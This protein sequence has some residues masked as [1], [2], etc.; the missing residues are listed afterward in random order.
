MTRYHCEAS[1]KGTKKIDSQLINNKDNQI[2]AAIASWIAPETFYG[3]NNVSN[4]DDNR[5][6]T[7]ANM[8]NAKTL[9]FGCGYQ[10]NCGQDVHISC[11]YNLMQ[12]YDCD[13]ET[14]AM[15]YAR[16]C[17]LK[18]SEQSEREG[19]GENVYIYNAPNAVPADA[20]E[21]AAEHWWGQ[22]FLDGIN[23]KV[24]FKQS[25]KDKSIDQKSF[26]QMAWAKSTKLGCG[27]Q[28]CGMKSFVVCRYSPA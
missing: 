5:L 11:I 14:G 10:E 1:R 20:F 17:A 21:A 12:V 2:K 13:T 6:Y 7:F 8:A 23:W 24:L 25:L 4:Y 28:T 16:T 15:E 18:Q 3:L 22:V 9:R 19:Y 27:I 26:T